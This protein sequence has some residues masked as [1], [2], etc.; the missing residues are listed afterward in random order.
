MKSKHCLAIALALTPLT[1]VMRLVQQLFIIDK[2]GY[3]TTQEMPW[4]LLIY[5][6][7]GII[8]LAAAV[9]IVILFA[10]KKELVSPSAVTATPSLGVFYIL[11]AVLIMVHSGINLMQKSDAPQALSYALTVT[12]ILSGVNFGLLGLGS[13]GRSYFSVS[14]VFGLFPPA[15]V[16][17]FA[18]CRFYGSF[19][20]AAVSKNMLST[21]AACA[22]ALLT[23]IISLAGSGADVSYRR[24]AAT[25][26]VYPVLAATSAPFAVCNLSDAS[27]VV[28]GAILLLFIPVAL[29][30]L[31]RLDA[32]VIIPEQ[33]EEAPE[34]EGGAKDEGLD[35]F[36][37]DI[38]DMEE[39]DINE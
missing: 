15:Y 18:V 20:H 2:N 29:I 37:Q 17:I 39:T 28:F 1:F 9:G 6:L 33:A 25:A 19:D 4:A 22:L 8:A 11:I 23:V 16:C 34:A 27:G 5:G 10:G 26:M 35:K 24:A 32:A 14:R 38:P 12:G 31:T 3:F 36:M 7:Y 21:V 30:T 13:L